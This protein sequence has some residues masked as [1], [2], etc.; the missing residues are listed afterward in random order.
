MTLSFLPEH[1]VVGEGE[2]ER[3]EKVRKVILMTLPE[4]EV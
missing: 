2:K 3:E 4:H 1:K